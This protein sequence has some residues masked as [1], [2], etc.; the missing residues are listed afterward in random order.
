MRK[1]IGNSLVYENELGNIKTE[2]ELNENERPRG[3]VNVILTNSNKVFMRPIYEHYEE[4][5]HIDANA[6][7]KEVFSKKN[8]KKTKT[9][10]IWLIQGLNT[11]K[12]VTS[13]LSLIMVSL[14]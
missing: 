8:N 10:K 13:G 9:K 12:G 4:S 6:L 11:L 5:G 7:K 14:K 1:K 3:N 2:I